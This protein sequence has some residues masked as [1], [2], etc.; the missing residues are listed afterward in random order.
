MTIHDTYYTKEFQAVT[1]FYKESEAA[2]QVGFIEKSIPLKQE[3]NILDLACGFGRHSIILAQ[4]GYSV[5]GYDQSSDYIQQ[6]KKAAKNANVEVIFELTD[7]RKLAVFQEFDVVL[8]MSSSL[9]FYEDDV[10]IDIFRRI[11]QALKPGG[12]F[13]F[14]QAN[15]FWLSECFGIKK[16]KGSKK[17]QDGLI[18]NY[19][20][21]FNATN[22]VLS[23]RSILVG[24][25]GRKESGWDLRYYT[26]P[27]LSMIMHKI[28]F[29][30]SSFHGDYDS[31]PYTVESKRLITIWGKF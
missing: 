3:D 2:S 6:A 24:K 16:H 26:F 12:N 27:E 18:H 13:L 25:N 11:C 1:E 15:I 19:E 17:L 21:T 4:K 30:L 31:S 5:V 20:T 28:G 7:M 14:D 23:R 29:K 8:S 10:N 9:A 22:C